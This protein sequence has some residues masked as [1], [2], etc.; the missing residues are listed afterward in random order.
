MVA[1]L[2]IEMADATWRFE[3]LHGPEGNI[4]TL[5][6]SAVHWP[7]CDDDGDDYEGHGE[8]GLGVCREGSPF[9]VANEWFWNARNIDYRP[10][11]DAVSR[12]MVTG[13][14]ADVAPTNKEAPVERGIH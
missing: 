1:D 2:Q 3:V 4:S 14:L 7:G 11:L 9:R 13:D 6:V 12:V 10:V 8:F 5:W